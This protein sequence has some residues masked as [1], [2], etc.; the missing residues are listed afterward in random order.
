M[1]LMRGLGGCDA[2]RRERPEG[3]AAYEG[4]SVQQKFPSCARISTDAHSRWP[5][6][7]GVLP[8]PLNGHAHR[9]RRATRAPDRCSV[10]FGDLRLTLLSA[11][12]ASP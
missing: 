7:V 4:T 10:W 6:H 5:R 9:P 12:A 3:K 8:C 11:S 1:E 2:R